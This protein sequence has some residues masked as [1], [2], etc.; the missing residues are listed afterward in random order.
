MQRSIQFFFRAKYVVQYKILFNIP[1][2]K[3]FLSVFVLKMDKN[4]TMFGLTHVNKYLAI[5][6]LIFAFFGVSHPISEKEGKNF[7]F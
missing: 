3:D 4:K 7:K 5:V 1:S 6:V 2:M